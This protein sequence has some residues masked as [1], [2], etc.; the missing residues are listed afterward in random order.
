MYAFPIGT[1][2][3][4]A[5][6]IKAFIVMKTGW[7]GL[8]A[9]TTCAGTLKSFFVVTHSLR[10]GRHVGEVRTV[11]H[12]EAGPPLQRRD[13]EQVG[14]FQGGRVRRPG[15][16]V[17]LH[18]KIARHHVHG[19]VVGRAR[20][21]LDEGRFDLG[22][23]VLGH[24]LGH[25]DLHRMRRALLVVGADLEVRGVLD[26]R[27]PVGEVDPPTRQ[28]TGGGVEV[29]VGEQVG[30]RA[31]A[32]QP[33]RTAAREKRSVFIRGGAIICGR[34]TRPQGR[35]SRPPAK[36]GRSRGRIVP[37]GKNAVPRR[38]GPYASRPTRPACKNA[39]C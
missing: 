20:I 38:A 19:P 16:G 8:P 12:H 31:A 2:A 7:V 15:L 32:A 1:V 13:A 10:T 26:V 30:L 37:C 9:T 36:P 28:G 18:G 35:S 14:L 24:G 33:S 3:V 21:D 29:R 22:P 5:E 6:K 39:P 27:P 4:V 23:L 11:A 34:S 25:G 17:D